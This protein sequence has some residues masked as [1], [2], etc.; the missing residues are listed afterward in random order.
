MQTDIESLGLGGCGRA[1]PKL[2]Q[3]CEDGAGHVGQPFPVPEQV[4]DC[5][6]SSK[7]WTFRA[8][9]CSRLGLLLTVRLR[10]ERTGAGASF[11]S[12]SGRLETVDEGREETPPSPTSAPTAPLPPRRRGR[13]RSPPRSLSPVEPLRALLPHEQEALYSGLSQAP[14]GTLAFGRRLEGRRPPPEGAIAWSD[15]LTDGP[16]RHISPAFVALLARTQAASR[17]RRP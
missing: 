7:S 10:R 16:G 13:S 12:L 9:T 6:S 11:C 5:L 14:S 1:A 4:P 3:V 8:V 17:P 15:E 2:L